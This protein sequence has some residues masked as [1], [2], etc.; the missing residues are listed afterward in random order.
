MITPRIAKGAV[1]F[2]RL[3]FEAPFYSA[4]ELVYPAVK[5]GACTGPTASIY[6]QN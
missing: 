2:I 5:C 6:N 4:T 1:G 3:G